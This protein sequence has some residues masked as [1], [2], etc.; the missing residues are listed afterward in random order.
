MKKI[1]KSDTFKVFLYC[2]C[3]CILMSIFNNIADIYNISFLH[4]FLCVLSVSFTQV[5]IVP[6]YTLFNRELHK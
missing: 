2:L 5:F 1:L 6:L 4:R 3:I